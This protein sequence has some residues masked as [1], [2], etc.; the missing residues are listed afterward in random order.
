[1][2]VFEE[3]SY[4]MEANPVATEVIVKRQELCTGEANVDSIGSLED[5]YMDQHL[6]VRSS[7]RFRKSTQGNK[8]FWHK[9]VA[10]HRRK[11]RRAVL[12][13]CKGHICKGPGNASVAKKPIKEGISG[14]DERRT[15]SVTT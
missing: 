4:K 7:R 8:G 14:R 3:S 5:G 1:M 15:R 12:T 9:L 6:V 11:I 13:L 2:D 10:A